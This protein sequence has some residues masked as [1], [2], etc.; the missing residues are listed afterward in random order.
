MHRDDRWQRASLG[1][2]IWPAFLLLTVAA[3]CSEPDR[4]G[5][6]VGEPGF[7]AQ[8]DAVRRG[9]SD[10]IRLD[11][12]AVTDEHLNELAGLEDKLR[13]INLS[14]SHISDAGMARISDMRK[15]EQ[16]RLSSDRVTDAGLACL[17]NLKKLRHLHLIGMPITDSGLAHL[18]ALTGLRSLYLDGT[19]TTEDGIGRLVKALPEVHLHYEGGHHRSDSRGADHEHSDERQHRAL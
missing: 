8:V 18:H 17:V 15:L 7:A 1:R 11:H 3:G 6:K 4:L 14:N 9:Q 2:G 5:A 13:R 10:Q 12:T 16:L 19:K